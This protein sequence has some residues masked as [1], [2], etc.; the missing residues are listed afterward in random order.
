LFAIG[1]ITGTVVGGQVAD[2]F[3]YRRISFA[4]ALV[5]AGTITLP[6]FLLQ[7]SVTITVCLGVAF[8]FFNALSRPSLL[9]AMAVC[10]NWI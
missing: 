4:V 10:R 8:A 5:I 3:A 9:A 2:R 1:N 7:S 6:W